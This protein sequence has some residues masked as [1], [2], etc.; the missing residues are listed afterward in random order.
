MYNFYNKAN[1]IKQIVF[2][3]QELLFEKLLLLQNLDCGSYLWLK[4]DLYK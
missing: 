4:I 1:S 3:K 2:K